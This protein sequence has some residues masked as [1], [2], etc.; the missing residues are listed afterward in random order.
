MNVLILPGLSSPNCSEYRAVYRPLLAEAD[1]RFPDGHSVALSLPGQLTQEAT[2]DGEFLI[3]RAVEYVKSYLNGYPR[4]EWALIA[5]SSGCSV[6]ARLLADWQQA[7]VK[8]A[9]F[10]GPP[11]FWLFWHMFVRHAEENFVKA[12]MTGVEITPS[13]AASAVP[14]E[15]LVPEIRCPL[16]VCTGSED[17][18]CPP[19]YLSY[20]ETVWAKK[21]TLS[22]AIVE[23]C[24]HTVSEAHPSLSNYI[25]TIFGW[26][27]SPDG[28]R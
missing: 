23:Q 6:A 24:P 21:D 2:I 19:S 10:W 16:L 8:K 25:D 11:P 1:R 18:F 7:P 4:D 14:F 9:V 22:F 5:R 12:E 26:L 15:S 27:T 17:E 13:I 3:P 20:L 28:G